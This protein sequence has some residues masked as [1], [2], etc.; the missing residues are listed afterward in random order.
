MG[1]QTALTAGGEGD[2]DVKGQGLY[3][4]NHLSKVGGGKGTKDEETI[5]RQQ[6]LRQKQGKGLLQSG[7]L[8]HFLL[9]ISTM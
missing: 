6:Q 2:S 5:R 9:K 4:R 3:Y 7:F 1:L 8:H